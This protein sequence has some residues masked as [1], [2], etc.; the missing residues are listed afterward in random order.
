MVAGLCRFI[1]SGRKD[2]TRKDEKTP[3]ETLILSSF[4]VVS[5]RVFVFSHGVLSSFSQALFH[6]F[7]F[8]NGI[9]PSFHLA[10]FCRFVY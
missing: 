4:C 2:A 8:S 10:L 5:F 7:V 6:N 9:F 3:F 1:F